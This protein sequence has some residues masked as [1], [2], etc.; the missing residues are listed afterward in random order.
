MYILYIL[1]D[2][3]LHTYTLYTLVHVRTLVTNFKNNF[4]SESFQENLLFTCAMF[5]YFL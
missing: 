1:C 3:K 2:Y 4:Q 5:A